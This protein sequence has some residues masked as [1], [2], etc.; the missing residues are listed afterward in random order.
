MT[1]ARCKVF[2]AIG[3]RLTR[4]PFC[5]VDVKAFESRKPARSERTAGTRHLQWREGKRSKLDVL[6]LECDDRTGPRKPRRAEEGRERDPQNGRE[7]LDGQIV[8]TGVHILAA[9]RAITLSVMS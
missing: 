9:L 3:H 6:Y 2:D 4:Q 5:P 7:D 8:D 1:G